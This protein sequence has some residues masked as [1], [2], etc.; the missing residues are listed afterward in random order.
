MPPPLLPPLMLMA[1]WHGVMARHALA[2]TQTTSE[3]PV[4]VFLIIDALL[5]INACSFCQLPPV[6]RFLRCEPAVQSA[7]MQQ[8]DVRHSGHIITRITSALSLTQAATT[9]LSV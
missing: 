7:V 2:H 4:C 6:V 9:N 5:I 1:Q 3:I 8:G